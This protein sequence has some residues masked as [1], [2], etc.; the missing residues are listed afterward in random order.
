VDPN[1]SEYLPEEELRRK[2]DAVGALGKE[3][4][5][6]YCGG[7]IAA[8]S[9]ALVLTL[10]GAENVAVYDGSMTEW[11]ADPSLPLE[12]GDAVLRHQV[13]PA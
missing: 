2:F 8:S 1:T 9:D 3:R 10:L 11:G 7:G 12:T 6:T 5:I 4:V 13:G